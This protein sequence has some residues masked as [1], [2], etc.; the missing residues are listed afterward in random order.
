MKPQLIEPENNS[1]LL[2]TLMT[3]HTVWRI[4]QAYEK[5]PV[6]STLALI[7]H[8]NERLAAQHSID[9]HI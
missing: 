6:K 4:Q 5:S 2:K 3:S 7:F 8:V 1:Q 9:E